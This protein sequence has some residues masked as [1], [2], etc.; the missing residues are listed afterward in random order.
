MRFEK[1]VLAILLFVGSQSVSHASLIDV[2]QTTA[3]TSFVAVGK[4][5]MLRI[6]GESE[7]ITSKLNLENK[8]VN[9]DVNVQLAKFKTGIETRDEH[10]KKK[11]LEIE[12][13]P[14][15]VLH[16]KDFSVAELKSGVK[17]E[18][19]FKANLSLHGVTKEV[20][21]KSKLEAISDSK[22]KIQAS[23]SIKLSD[24]NID[25]PSYAGIKV[26]DSVDFEV[27]FQTK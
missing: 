9:G 22:F 7:G 3:K 12:K 26:A 17:R 20:E 8:L 24:F 25:I 11:Y 19:N 5:A 15:A 13:F 16:I 1:L 6:R 27:Q 18:L 2:D 21:V 14:E 23:A 10:M 4:P